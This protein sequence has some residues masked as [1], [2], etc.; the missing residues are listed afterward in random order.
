ML[1]GRPPFKGPTPLDTVLQ[2]LHEEP[3]RP[4]RL[5]PKVPRDL[6]TVCLKCLEKEPTRRYG[7]AQQLA[8]DLRRFRHGAPTLARPVGV[9]EWAWKWA[10]RRPVQAGLLLGLVLVTVLGFAGV[11]WQWQ[12]AAHSPRHRPGRETR[13]RAAKR[14]GR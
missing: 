14:P 4:S 13:K 12:E 7:S 1:T 11:T 5:R 8:D 10:R 9:R 3:V 2:V 6:E